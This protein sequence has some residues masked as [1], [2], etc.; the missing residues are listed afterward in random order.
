MSPI[1]IILS[2]VSI[3]LAIA[4]H[5]VAVHFWKAWKL[6]KSPL[7]L[8]IC[9]LIGYPIFTN[10]SSMIFIYQDPRLSV[11]IMLLAN[12]VLLINFWVCFRWQKERFQE[13]RFP[14]VVK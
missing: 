8:A 12:A 3:V 6:R 7:S 1:E 10:T 14:R 4:W 9:A 5:F 2:V 11:G 13:E